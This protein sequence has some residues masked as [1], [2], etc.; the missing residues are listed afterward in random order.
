[1][2]KQSN[3]F[4]PKVK[5]STINDFNNIEMNKNSSNGLKRMMIGVI[6]K[7]KEGMYKHL[8]ESK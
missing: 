8:N 3:M 7:I 1:M 6:S 5:S 4:P 2:K